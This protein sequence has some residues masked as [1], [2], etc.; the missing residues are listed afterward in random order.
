M[1]RKYLIVR[2]F[3]TL[4][5]MI[6]SAACSTMTD[7][8]LDVAA[9]SPLFG[10]ID[11]EQAVQIVLQQSSPDGAM[12]DTG[13]FLADPIGFSYKKS[14]TKT[15][16]VTRNK[17]PVVVEYLEVVTGNVSWRD[18]TE[19][20]PVHKD[21]GPLGLVYVVTLEYRSSS[22]DEYGRHLVVDK[23]DF[24]CGRK[25]EDFANVVNAFRVLTQPD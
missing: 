19:I 22:L 25:Y 2:S 13:S 11:K 12:V 6:L 9:D 16:T 7:Y 24:Y 3:S 10:K 4:V 5:L 21:Y 20:R 18:V 17:K 23:L 14:E 8:P 15:R 1:Q